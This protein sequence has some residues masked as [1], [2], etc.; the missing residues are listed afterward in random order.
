[1]EKKKEVVPLRTAQDCVNWVE[2]IAN[3]AEKENTSIALANARMSCVKG[4][5]G[6]Q[7]LLIEYKRLAAQAGTGQIHELQMFF[8][9]RPAQIE[10]K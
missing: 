4:L 7:K 10:K 5:L 8:A 6:V 9:S 1:M 3:D 2:K